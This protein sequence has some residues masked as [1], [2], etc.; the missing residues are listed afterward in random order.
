MLEVATLALIALT[1]AA[2]IL[3]I[4]M[5][6]GKAI[7]EIDWPDGAAGIFGRVALFLMS[8]LCGL[9]VLGSAFNLAGLV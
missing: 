4:S 6:I 7:A 3:Y 8:P 2:A 1:H 5:T 9:V